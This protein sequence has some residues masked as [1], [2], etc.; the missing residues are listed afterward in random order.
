MYILPDLPANPA[1]AI[2][3]PSIRFVPKTSHVI[4]IAC[5]LLSSISSLMSNLL[6]DLTLATFTWIDSIS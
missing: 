2:H 5:W 3:Y 6:Y 4:P 1:P